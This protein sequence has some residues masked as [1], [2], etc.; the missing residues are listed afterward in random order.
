M[1][2]IASEPVTAP[3]PVK[4]PIAKAPEAPFRPFT[5]KIKGKKVRMRLHADLESQVIRELNKKDL[6]SIV[7]EKGDFW[8]VQPPSDIKAYIFRSFVL[9]NV[10]EGNRVNV[11]LE[12]STDSPIIGHFNAGDKVSGT[13]CAANNKWLEIAP[14]PKAQF[15]VA[16][17]YVEFAGGPEL[18]VQTDKRRVTVEQLLDATALLSK[19]ELRKSFEEI[20]MDRL[21]HSY[22][23]IISDYADFPE[24]VDQA[25]EALASLQEAYIQKRISFLEARASSSSMDDN[26]LEEEK[27]TVE[28]DITK[29]AVDA[30][31]KMKMWEPI[32]EAIYLSWAQMNEDKTLEQYYEEQKL[33]AVPITGIVEAYVSPVKNKPGD[34]IIRDK[35]LPVAYVYST[36]VNLQNLVGKK[37]TMIGIP[38]SS[39]NFAFP[40]F[41]IISVE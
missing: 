8:A 18:K 1:T 11:R 37:V 27:G 24:H 12:P 6:L 41:F 33:A 14:P 28:K 19:A 36:Q 15:Y 30:T 5:G 39:N 21:T 32:E 9:D 35:D 3:A 22:N 4:A 7:G 26:D 29:V 16:K 38:R 10:V 20:D 13:I 25:K 31:D 17:D 40:T 34:F 2:P 23:T